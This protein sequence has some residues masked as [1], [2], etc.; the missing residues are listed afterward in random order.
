MSGGAPRKCH[1][2][3]LKLVSAGPREEGGQEVEKSHAEGVRADS[4]W[5][6][7]PAVL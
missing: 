3:I 1:P 6:E 7:N 2:T 5:E 4:V